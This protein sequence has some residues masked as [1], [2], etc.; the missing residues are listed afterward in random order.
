VNLG[1]TLARLDWP[2]AGQAGQSLDATFVFR[3]DA[4]PQE[5][6]DEWAFDLF[7]Q[8]VGPDGALAAE[9]RAPGLPGK[10]WRAGDLIVSTARLEVPEGAGPGAY[11][12]RASLYDARQRKNAV[13]FAGSE[14]ARP[15]LLLEKRVAVR[16]AGS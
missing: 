10:R 5:P 3:I 7:V 11:I 16:G 13:W 6:H 12:L 1:W 15:I 9:A 2:D 14:M 4:L 8:L